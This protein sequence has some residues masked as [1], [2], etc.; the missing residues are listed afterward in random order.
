MRNTIPVAPH[1]TNSELR[2][3]LKHADEA[4][5][6]RIRVIIN[7]QDGLARID[8]ARSFS[9]TQNSITNWVKRYNAG[10]SDALATNKGG[11][12]EG[13]PKWDTSIFDELVKEINKTKKYWSIPLM[14]NWIK[15]HYKLAIPEQTVWYHMDARNMSYKSARPHP[16]LGDKE[17]QEAFKKGVS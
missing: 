15:E 16:H 12:P 5:K 14:M 9:I 13:N 6:T 11:R 4:Q 1:A 17:R 2:Q 8:I 7:I 10:G 3:A